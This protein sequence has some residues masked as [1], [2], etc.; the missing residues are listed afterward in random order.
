MSPN[1]TT[2]LQ[3]MQSMQSLSNSWRPIGSQCS[4]A[5]EANAKGISHDASAASSGGERG[6]TMMLC[7]LRLKCG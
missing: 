1:D 2:Q 6:R 3:G 4:A 5:H 7:A